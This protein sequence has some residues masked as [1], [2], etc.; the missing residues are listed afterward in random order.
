L[1]LVTSHKI[2]LSHADHQIDTLAARVKE[3]EATLAA[4]KEAGFIDEKGEVRKVLGTLPVTADGC[5][6][7]IGD[8]L[9]HHTAGSAWKTITLCAFFPFGHEYDPCCDFK[10]VYSTRSAAEKARGDEEAK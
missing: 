10:E 9:L 4:C 6:A 2:I 1:R 8:Y 5:V 7:G 3:L